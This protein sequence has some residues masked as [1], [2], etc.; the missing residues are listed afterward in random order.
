MDRTCRQKI[1]CMFMY[2]DGER[3]DRREGGRESKREEQK[4]EQKSKSTQVAL[5]FGSQ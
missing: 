3:T 2:K 5:N 1:K 4:R